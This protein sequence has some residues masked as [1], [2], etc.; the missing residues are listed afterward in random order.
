MSQILGF[1]GLNGLVDSAVRCQEFVNEVPC[2][3]ILQLLFGNA[4]G[5]EKLAQIRCDVVEL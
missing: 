3:L 2:P 5:I 4:G 1:D